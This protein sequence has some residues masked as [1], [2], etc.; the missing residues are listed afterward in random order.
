VAVFRRQN[1]DGNELRTGEDLLDGQIAAEDAD[2][3]NTNAG[4]TNAGALFLDNA[5]VSLLCVPVKP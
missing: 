3:R 5:E 1:F 2:V 4:G